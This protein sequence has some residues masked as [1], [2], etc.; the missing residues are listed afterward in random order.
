VDLYNEKVVQS[1]M[2]SIFR[3]PVNYDN[4]ENFLSEIDSKK[5]FASSLTG[6]SIY[7]AEITFPNYLIMGSESHGIRQEIYRFA[8]NKIKVPQMGKVESMNVSIATA[9]ILAEFRR[10]LM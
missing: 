10:K 7:E 6:S 9:V 5:V 4:L 3:M 2:G 8:D 1:S